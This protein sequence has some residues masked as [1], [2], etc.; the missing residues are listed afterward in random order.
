MDF[1]IEDDLRGALARVLS[2]FDASPDNVKLVR[3]VLGALALDRHIGVPQRPIN[4]TTA[5][6]SRR[7]VA[8]PRDEP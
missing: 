8:P 1:L 5:S 4:A 7:D 6:S 2:E 3:E